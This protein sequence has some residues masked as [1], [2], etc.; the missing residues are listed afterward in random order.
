LEIPNVET[1]SGVVR[2]VGVTDEDSVMECSRVRGLEKRREVQGLISEK[3]PW[4]VC[5]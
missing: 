5:L 2:G 4:I 1:Q 3:H